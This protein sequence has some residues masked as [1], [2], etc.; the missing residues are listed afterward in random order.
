VQNVERGVGVPVP[1]RT[2]RRNTCAPDETPGQIKTKRAETFRFFAQ[3]CGV[4]A[5]MC[6]NPLL[7]SFF[8]VLL[9]RVERGGSRRSEADQ[10]PSIETTL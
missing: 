6:S 8:V 2:D 10:T 1:E 5:P 3:R 9:L 4:D 7:S